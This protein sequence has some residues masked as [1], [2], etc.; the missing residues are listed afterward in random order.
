MTDLIGYGGFGCVYYPSLTCDGKITKNKKFVSKLLVNNKN[1][2]REINNGILIKKIKNYNKFFAPILYHCNVNLNIM[3][4][5]LFSTCP[6]IN[7]YSDKPFILLKLNYISDIDYIDYL[8]SN[9]NNNIYFI[10]I[11][12]SYYYLINS[13]QILHD[14]NFIH[15]DIKAD[16][17]L[18]DM[19]FKIPIIIDFG[20]SY[21][22]SSLSSFSNIDHLRKFFYIYAPDYSL[23][24]PEIQIICF[25]IASQDVRNDSNYILNKEDLYSILTA[26]VNANSLFK[27]FSLDFKYEYSKALYEANLYLVG[28]KKDTIIKE[29]IKSNN[30]WDLYSLSLLYLQVLLSDYQRLKTNNR[31]NSFENIY[32]LLSQIFLQ[33]LSPY[34]TKRLS[35]S[36][37]KKLLFELFGKNFSEYINF[38]LLEVKLSI[39]D[40]K[41][42]KTNIIPYLN[43]F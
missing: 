2:L 31:L 12:N 25:L 7:K 17:I 38:S 3:D 1:T 18:F 6:I 9:I 15:Y 13:L 28:Q 32:V 22:I 10:N 39:N 20:L 43:F 35:F 42:I 30:T 37:L 29:L 36:N 34:P 24:C 23:W 11:L 14:N 4:N 5:N 19:N 41:E 33:N 16:N 27:Y 8:T 21:K 26:Y 40:F